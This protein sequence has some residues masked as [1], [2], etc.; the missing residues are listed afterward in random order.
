MMAS[1]ATAQPCADLLELM[2]QPHRQYRHVHVAG[3]KGKGSTAA[4]IGA[5]LEAAGWRCAVLS[6]PHVQCITERLRIDGQAVGQEALSKALD[7]A[8][9]ARARAEARGTHGMEATWFDTF[10]AASLH[11]CAEAQVDWAVVECGL[12]GRSDSTN[13]LASPMA[14]LT[15]VELEHTEVLGDTLEAIAREKCGIASPDGA[16][17][18]CVSTDLSQ[19]VHDIAREQRVRTCTV[20]PRS[21]DHTEDNLEISRLTLDELGRR[22][23][24][25]APRSNARL[26]RLSRCLLG[27]QQV[28][29]AHRML[30]A[31]QERLMSACG[32]EVLLD[33]AHTPASACSLVAVTR[34]M[35]S[36]RKP[37]VLLIGML[38]DKDHG[39]VSAS[40]SA[41]LPPHVVCVDVSG[42]RG[43]AGKLKTQMAA[44]GCTSVC[45]VPDVASALEAALDA[46]RHHETWL[47]VVGSF[48]LC[49]SVRGILLTAIDETHRSQ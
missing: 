4:L 12:G 29:R 16:L 9:A 41:L 20:L 13:V 21:Q 22:G 15:S 19:I 30:P 46:A 17:V 1:M 25:C 43:V 8:L 28:Q 36:V 2:G 3:S 37:P 18:A 27:P 35:R 14:L 5:A 6:S 32:V 48:R 39:Q 26:S 44:A 40:M 38:G 49:G 23:F 10:V 33:A 47:V 45:A 11:A 31:R 7:A 42:G 34:R 24:L